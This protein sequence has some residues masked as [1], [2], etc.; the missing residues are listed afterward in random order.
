V[1]AN[2]EKTTKRAAN[3]G[4]KTMKHLCQPGKEAILFGR[5]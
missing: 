4:F 1:P 3:S 2:K 5:S